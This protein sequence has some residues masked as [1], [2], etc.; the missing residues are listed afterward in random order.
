[1]KLSEIIDLPGDLKV[2]LCNDLVAGRINVAAIWTCAA[3][4][5]VVAGRIKRRRL[6][7][8]GRHLDH[9]VAGR[10]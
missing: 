5:H 1:M 9:V 8:L 6:S 4:D 10:P 3:Q 7:G 2:G